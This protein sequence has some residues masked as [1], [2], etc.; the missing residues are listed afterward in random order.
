MNMKNMKKHILGIATALTLATPA[1]ATSSVSVIGEIWNGSAAGVVNHWHNPD[2]CEDGVKAFLKASKSAPRG[3]PGVFYYCGLVYSPTRGPATELI[4][5][6]IWNGPAM[7]T[8][9]FEDPTACNNFLNGFIN[10]AKSAPRGTPIPFGVCT[11]K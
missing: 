5:S 6:F 4:G 3:K 9:E 10:A 11:P 1:F 8:A 2:S 7:F